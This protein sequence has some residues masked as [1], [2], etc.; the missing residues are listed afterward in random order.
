MAN[1]FGPQQ[2]DITELPVGPRQPPLINRASPGIH[3]PNAYEQDYDVSGG[4]FG[5]ETDSAI[6]DAFRQSVLNPPQRTQM[7]YPK[8]T[9]AGLMKGLEILNEPLPSEKN[10]VYVDGKP[11]QK[12]QVYTDPETGEKKFITTVKD[13]SFMDQVLK[14]MP[15]AVSPAVDI[16][17]QP[18]IDAVTDWEMRNKGLQM[19]A[20]AEANAAL[21][22]QRRATAGAIPQRVAQ[23]ERALDIKQMDAETRARLAQLRDLPDSEKLRLLQEGRVSLEELRAANAM[24]RLERGGEIRSGQI[25][26]QGRIRS[27]QIAQQGAI[28]SGQIEQRGG[29][30]RDV[31][32]IRGEEARKTKATPSAQGAGAANYPTQQRVAMQARAAQIANQNPEWAEFITINEEG[33]PE[34][35][36][37]SWYGGPDKATYDKIYE[38]IYG[39]QRAAPITPAPAA[40]T[41]KPTPKPTPKPAAKSEQTAAQQV[42]KQYSP[43]R[44]QTRISTDGGKTWKVVEGRQ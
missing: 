41:T 29:I 30:A 38:S 12:Q 14:A 27:G 23:G 10:R 35:E 11:F 5:P 9:L 6:L 34:I 19:G 43:S 2:Q 37:P 40:Q 24:Q 22:Q 21:A 8:N 16:L 31:A 3:V 33:F 1:I 42:I 7:T 18:Y 36:P 15:A 44:N 20:Q 26:Q 13:P 25:E 4:E 39:T 28:T 17:N 32:R